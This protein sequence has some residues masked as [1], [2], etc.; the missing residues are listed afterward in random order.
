MGAPWYV[1]PAENPA[2][3]DDLLTVSHEGFAVVNIQNGYR[4]GDPYYAPLLSRTA[5]TALLGY[6]DV[7]YG[8]RPVSEILDESAAWLEHLAIVGVMFDRVPPVVSQCWW[9]VEI[10]DEVRGIGAQMV[11][12]NP[13]VVPQQGVVAAA[14]VTCVAELA[15]QDFCWWQAPSWLA[16][17]ER[18]KVWMLLHGVPAARQTAALSLCGERG[19]GYA[20]ATAGT[21]PNPWSTLPDVEVL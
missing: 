3:W 1:H 12:V 9:D 11:A 10:I 21:L 19:A 20:W 7:A 15:W 2:A 8:D 17:V 18:H 4:A 5:A 16:S 6:V 14:D 13:G